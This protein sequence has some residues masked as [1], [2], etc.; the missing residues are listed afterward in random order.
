MY[1]AWVEDVLRMPYLA[2]APAHWICAQPGS[3]FK[4]NDVIVEPAHRQHL[5]HRD[6]PCLLRDIGLLSV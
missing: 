2:T 5:P 4:E 6:F 3:R 1:V